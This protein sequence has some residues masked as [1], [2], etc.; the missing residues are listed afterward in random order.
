VS[1]CSK[2]PAPSAAM[3]NAARESRNEARELREL[4]ADARDAGDADRAAW[5]ENAAKLFA[6]FADELEKHV[7]RGG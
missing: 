7:D 3:L 6:K 4:A 1:R 2:K 5:A